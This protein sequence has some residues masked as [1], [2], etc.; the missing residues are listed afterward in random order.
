V[1]ALLR[2]IVDRTI[3]SESFG[4]GVAAESSRPDTLPPRIEPL[5]GF[6]DDTAR[7]AA[8]ET[9]RPPQ[10]APFD[11]VK[12][13][14]PRTV[15]SNDFT[16][17]FEEGVVADLSFAEELA[18]SEFPPE[19]STSPAAI[20][21]DDPEGPRTVTSSDY[22]IAFEEE[23]PSDPPPVDLSATMAIQPDQTLSGD[24]AAPRAVTDSDLTFAFVEEASPT[25]DD[26]RATHGHGATVDLAE[27][28]SEQMEMLT[29]MWQGTIAP[30][31]KPG[32]TI[33]AATPGGASQTHLV[34]RPRTVRAP[35]EPSPHGA[36]Y[37]LLDT[38][39]KGGMGVVYSARQASIDRTVAIK[40]IR[41]EMAADDDQRQKFLSEAVVTGDLD[42]PN[43]VPIYDLGSNE[44]GA[45]FYSMKR[46]EGTPWM[47]VVR[48]KSRSENLEILMK[49]ADAV[50]FAHSR[51]V[52][53]RDLKPEN[54]MLG[55]YG[56]VLVM[57]WGLALL[58][59][60]FRHLGSVMQ[61]G[62]MGGTPAYMAPEMASGPLD[63]IGT[64]S[65]VY[66]LGAIL[67]EVLTGKPPHAGKDVMSCLY[68]VARNEI[69]A[70]D[71]SG[72]LMDIARKAMATEIQNR[73]NSVLEFQ[74]AI[75]LYHSH[76]ESI[77]LSD[78]ADED[79][80]Q[81][82]TTRDY[83]DFARAVFGFQEALSLWDGNERASRALLVAKSAYAEC[84][85][86]K[87]DLDL[88]ASLLDAEEPSFGDLRRKVTAAQRERSVRQ[89]RLKLMVRTAQG[90]VATVVVVVT[91]AFFLIRAQ[92]DRAV[93]AE[94]EATA[95]ATRADFEATNARAAEADA[96]TKRDQA[97]TAEQV[98][99]QQ[100]DRAEAA[101][102]EA[103]ADRDKA[104]TAEQAA[105]AAEKAEA[106]L[107]E[108][109]QILKQQKEY[110]AYI[111]Q[112]GLVAA[113]IDENAFGYATRLLDDCPPHLRNWEWGRLMHLCRQSA[114]TF[115]EDGPIDAACYSPDGRRVL[116]G[117]WEGHAREWDVATGQPVGVIEHGMYVH[118]VAY[119]PDC[120][121]IATGS[122]DE[123]G[124][125]RLWN[126]ETR[127]LVKTFNG[128]TDAVLSVA[129]SRDG[130]RLLSGSYD[131]TARLWDVDS[132]EQLRVFKGHTF[133]VWSAAFSPDE[134]H[135]VTASQDGTAI[136]WSVASEEK[137]APFTGHEGPVYSAAFSSDGQHVATAGYD[138]R[139]LIWRPD[140]V[141]PFD[142]ASLS[143]NSRP[144]KP[145]YLALVGHGAPVRCVRFSADGHT[146]MSASHDN[147]IKLWELSQAT[148]R[149]TLRGHAGWVRTCSFSPDGQSVLS[150][151]YDHQAKIWNT[152]QYEEVRTFGGH[153]DGLLGASFSP[154]G[155]RI[156]TASRDRT[157]KIQEI[158]PGRQP[159]SLSEGHAF[160]VSSVAFSP[161]GRQVFTG[162]GDDTIRSWDVAKGGEIRTF[163]HT[164]RE[165]IFALSSDGQRLLTGSDA[166]T[167]RLL[168]VD[169]GNVLSELTGHRSEV[170]A[171]AISPDGQI[172]YTGDAAGRGRLWS[173][174]DGQRLHLLEGHS[175][176]ITA[177]LFL[178]GGKRLLTSSTDNSVGQWDVATGK[179]LIAQVLKHP[180]GVTAMAASHNGQYVVTAC[181]DH[182]IRLWKLDSGPRI[183][184]EI[185]AAGC[186][187]SS[188]AISADGRRALTACADNKVRLWDLT[189]GAEI[190]GARA[191]GAGD[192]L[193]DTGRNA[194]WSAVFSP[195]GAHVATAG[196]NDAKLWQ[197]DNGREVM[198]FSPH[199]AVAGAAF[200]PDGQR[201]AT[202]S[203]DG[204]IKVW[205][206]TTGAVELKF[207]ASP[208][209][210]VNS[211]MFSPDGTKLLSASDDKTA[212]VWDASTGK[213]LVTLPG[214]GADD[215]HSDS[216]RSARFSQ[217]GKRVVTGS[218]DKTARVWDLE[219]GRSIAVLKGHDWDVL[220]AVFSDDGTKV[221]TG[222][223]DKTVRI[224]D[225]ATGAVLNVLQG[226]TAAVTSVAFTPDGSRAATGGQDNAVKLWDA[227]TGKEILHLKQHSQEISSVT[228]SP[229]GKLLLTGS[230]D[231]TAVLWPAADW[232]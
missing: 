119:S 107:R 201:V 56:E 6:T 114:Q 23:A 101:E 109:E 11:P 43:I 58:A 17:A 160:L 228:F 166:G 212:K 90:L 113:K 207:V 222:S 88:A 130:K 69:Q 214:D 184:R 120:Q 182:R 159:T 152:T 168:D 116:T 51:G 123:T 132:G 156:V 64:A 192:A 208:D 203:W 112:V 171:V 178:A 218:S 55:D 42:H 103:Q 183:L 72:E 195:D 48:Q 108:Q 187:V 47:K 153:D 54:V 83:Q 189:S 147:T 175:R 161:D 177:A 59:P 185:D 157:A 226:H 121:L 52:V 22:T 202:C 16:M 19:E 219:T 5:P 129:F 139:I 118:A 98:A 224:W 87:G 104:V 1:R 41:R 4:A 25:N 9:K 65:D 63:R 50:A 131:N 76:S 146:L 91:A 170:T 26:P 210:Y 36:D 111:A 136:I 220:A 33:K 190:H 61:S 39:G 96:E 198:A 99:K 150:A 199:G 217:D 82:T 60:R 229:N 172:L 53:H 67:Y 122:N 30:D 176:K 24:P 126:A 115:R 34:V 3:S 232:H 158:A 231:G 137:G 163:D 145:N 143:T 173:A 77:L 92:R 205:N 197:I 73:Y 14:G 167:C 97:V 84:A 138:K 227:T 7:T 181:E 200:S 45:L 44:A 49:V 85:M 209:K 204:T 135:I 154:D 140:Q 186:A 20:E 174:A 46:V 148:C 213:L 117:S 206:P 75:R 80:A 100:R 125:L 2:K 86:A 13:D 151:G 18:P 155:Q 40:M 81:A 142:F 70:T 32:M 31:T 71:E 179:E 62:G 211:I 105:V 10:Q 149:Q 216:V 21:G 230:R 128:H 169:T 68:A 221:M 15:S 188:V 215:G 141:K 106:A 93:V 194:V 180:Q 94:S 144:A 102:K 191:G 38:I 74:A 89:R 165:G 196:G 193:I 27:M 110:E 225:V 66:L 164:G 127:A 29:G 223:E 57:D 79:L 134:S 35:Q 12:E 162:A 133:W 28:Q 78:R 37:E 8:D 124:E 95:Q